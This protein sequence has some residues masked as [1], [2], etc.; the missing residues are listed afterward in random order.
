METASLGIA[1]K[2]TNT[3]GFYTFSLATENTSNRPDLVLRKQNRSLQFKCF[4]FSSWRH[5][6][7]PTDFLLTFAS[8]HNSTCSAF[9]IEQKSKG[10]TV[11]KPKK[12]SLNGFSAKALWNYR[13]KSQTKFFTFLSRKIQKNY[14]DVT[15]CQR[16]PGTSEAAS[17]Q[18]AEAGGTMIAPPRTQEDDRQVKDRSAKDPLPYIP[19]SG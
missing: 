10:S 5:G 13:S 16:R 6:R 8:P 3:R 14:I 11:I 12:M 15:G 18:T 7:D 4:F 17:H 19:E 2:R 1:A 9:E